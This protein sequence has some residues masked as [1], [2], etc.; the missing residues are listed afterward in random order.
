MKVHI[1][2]DMEGIYRLLR[3]LLALATSVAALP[4]S[5]D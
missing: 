1:S 3:V 4:Y 2:V 5:Y